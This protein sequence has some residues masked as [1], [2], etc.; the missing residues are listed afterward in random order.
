MPGEDVKESTLAKAV[1]VLACLVC[2]ML[3]GEAVLQ[4]LMLMVIIWYTF[5]PTVRLAL[6]YWEM[7]RGK[8]GGEKTKE[9]DGEGAAWRRKGA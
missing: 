3:L 9:D 6:R 1:H 7:W 4:F 2:V 8:Q 5:W